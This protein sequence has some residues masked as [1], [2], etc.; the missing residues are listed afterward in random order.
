[1][2]IPLSEARRAA[3]PLSAPGV[4]RVE[5]VPAPCPL[6]RVF[7]RRRPQA[8]AAGRGSP[9]PGLRGRLCQRRVP[10]ARA[11]WGSGTSPGRLG[12]HRARCSH[13]IFCGPEGAPG[14]GWGP[15]DQRGAVLPAR[16][17][18]RRACA[19]GS[20]GR[21]PRGAWA[22]SPAARLTVLSASRKISLA[23]SKEQRS[24][25][26]SL[27]REP[28]LSSSRNRLARLCLRNTPWASSWLRNTETRG[29]EPDAAR[30][31]SRRAPGVR[32]SWRP[33]CVRAGGLLHHVLT[34][35]THPSGPGAPSSSF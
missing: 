28:G 19:C 4:A 11:V 23:S 20:P 30:R 15:T 35:H 8:G 24:S 25:P 1:M 16:G 34:P 29:R 33:L 14:S 13:C 18:G 21:T 3:S 27:S 2:N 17:P 5:A 9:G 31:V 22:R 7:L 26:H 12:T 6:T 32:A 10:R